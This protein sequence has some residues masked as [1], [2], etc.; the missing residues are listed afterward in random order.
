MQGQMGNMKAASRPEL[1]LSEQRTPQPSAAPNMPFK[2]HQLKQL[3]AQCLVFLAFRYALSCDRNSG[4]FRLGTLIHFGYCCF[5]CRNN[6][7]PRKPHLDIALGLGENLPVE[8][9]H[10]PTSVAFICFLNLTQISE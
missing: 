9:K 8:S 2:E 5:L 10:S 3:R 1:G 6:M 7:P 4:F